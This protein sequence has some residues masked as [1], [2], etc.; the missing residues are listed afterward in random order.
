MVESALPSPGDVIAGKYRIDSTIGQG[1]MGVV[2]GAFDQSLGRQVAIKFL[3]PNRAAIEGAA[4]RFSR[5]ARA[6]ASIQGEHVVR[7]H[8]VGQLPNGAPFIVMEHLRGSDLAH[9][10][11]SRGGL[12]VDYACD[13]VLQTCQALAQA[14]ARDIVHRD[15]KPQNLFLTERPD[16]SPCVKVLDFGI[17]KAADTD[18]SSPKLT[19][20]E[21]VMG[22]PLYMSPEQVRSLKNVDHRADI[23][24]LGAILFELL[25]ASPP[26]DG[27]SASALHAAI[28]MDAPA[29]LRARRPD[30]PPHIEAAILR[31]LEKDPARRF[32]TVQE[33]SA[34]IAAGNIVSASGSNPVIVSV[35]PPAGG[36]GTAS[37]MDVRSGWQ[38][39]TAP[40]PA[41]RSSN[42]AMIIGGM[43]GAALLVLLAI[44]G[45]AAYFLSRSAVT[46][47]ET[48]IPAPA[49]ATTTVP[50]ITADPPAQPTTPVAPAPVPTPS[51]KPAAKD[52]GPP[53]SPDDR[54]R[55]LASTMQGSCDHFHMMM[56]MAKTPDERKHQAAMAKL[57]N[58]IMKPAIRCQRQVCREACNILNDD[59]CRRTVDNYDR[60][61]PAK[62]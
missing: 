10:L 31:C 48:P 20:T 19:S 32:Q 33:L 42:T 38:Q 5:E 60:D 58:C 57:Q 59:A 28:A 4:A 61:F 12:A 39:A 29:S 17:S 41:P 46:V 8:E 16:G 55:T 13:L 49:T 11:Q 2:L 21:T 9:I 3:R 50:A 40:Q 34:A 22:T 54:D 23:W 7:V 45:T 43:A 25:A 53:P 26:F 18:E 1:G 51:T 30:V 36:F 35:S 62:Y 52:A 56:S 24:A 14:H 6:A 47:T 27:P 37:T 44:G 15:L